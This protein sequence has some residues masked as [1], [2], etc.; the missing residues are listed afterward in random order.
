MFF[1]RYETFLFSNWRSRYTEQTKGLVG[2]EP[3]YSACIIPAPILIG[4]KSDPANRVLFRCE[5]KTRLA[6]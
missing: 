6:A 4:R 5:K 1:I 2:V 3:T